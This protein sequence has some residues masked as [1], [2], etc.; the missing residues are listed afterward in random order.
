MLSFAAKFANR[1]D[2][3]FSASFRSGDGVQLIDEMF[4]EL[5]LHLLSIFKRSG[6]PRFFILSI[7]LALRLRGYRRALLKLLYRRKKNTLLS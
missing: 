1:I 5:L 3:F 4:G 6:I 7:A 2:I